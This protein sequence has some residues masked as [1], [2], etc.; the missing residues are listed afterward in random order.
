[1][2]FI[3]ACFYKIAFINRTEE[4]AAKLSVFYITVLMT[5]NVESLLLF[6]LRCFFSIHHQNDIMLVIN[7]IIV[8]IINYILF[9]YNKKYIYI[10]N[11]FKISYLKGTICYI[12]CFIATFAIAIAAAYYKHNM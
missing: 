9:L 5:I 12:S 10:I 3:F 8:L 2:N 1:M 11:K 4:Q 6:I 7:F